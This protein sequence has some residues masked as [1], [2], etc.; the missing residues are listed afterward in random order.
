M[1]ARGHRSGRADEERGRSTARPR[2]REAGSGEERADS[3][4]GRDDVTPEIDRAV[5][6]WRASTEVFDGRDPRAPSEP[7][8]W[9]G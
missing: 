5:D 6:E 9:I 4:R 1:E 8:L 7:S 3:H 2:R